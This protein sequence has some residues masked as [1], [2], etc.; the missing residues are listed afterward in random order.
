MTCTFNIF[1]DHFF[2]KCLFQHKMSFGILHL[3]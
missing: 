1:L 3:G 2:S